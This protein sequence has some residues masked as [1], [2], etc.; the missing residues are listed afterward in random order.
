MSERSR[1]PS[2]QLPLP[3]FGADPDE[4]QKRNLIDQLIADTRLY[5]TASQLKELLDFT[6]RLRTVAPFNALLLHTQRPGITYVA[7]ARDWMSRHRRAPKPHARPMVIL[8][9]F[10]PVDFVYD[11]LDVHPPLPAKVYS[12][13]AVGHLPEGWLAKA[14]ARVTRTAIDL[15]EANQGDNKGGQVRP[16]EKFDDPAKLNRF[17][18]VLNKNH[19]P[20]TQFR[21]LAHELGHLYLGHCGADRKRGVKFRRPT[22]LAAREVEAETVAYLVSKRSGISP[23][24]ESYLN[25]Y[26]GAFEDFDLH[27]VMHACG[28]VERLLGLPLE[29]PGDPLDD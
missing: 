8:R 25:R 10:G 4:Q 24:S 29:I 15:I 16:I 22:S 3:G 5:S 18:I 19:P 27:A 23:R 26:Q 6:V 11:V 21:V 1:D 9:N 7:T 14:K 20:L 17:E 2:P 12:F 28:Q 13:P